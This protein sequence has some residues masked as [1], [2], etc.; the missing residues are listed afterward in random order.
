[1]CLDFPELSRDRSFKTNLGLDFHRESEFEEMVQLTNF[2]KRSEFIKGLGELKVKIGEEEKAYFDND[3]LIQRFLG[4]TP[5]QLASNESY[6]KKEAKAAPKAEGAEG[7]E[8][9]AA[10][11]EGEEGEAPEVTL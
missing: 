2:S 11:A 9:E 4:L 7:A 6:K 3:Y 10:P 1:M 5:D 8:G